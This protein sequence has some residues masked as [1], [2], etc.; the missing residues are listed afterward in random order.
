MGFGL[1]I[2]LSYLTA[3]LIMRLWPQ[4]TIVIRP[5]TLVGAGMAALVMTLFAALLPIRRV[6]A[7][8]PA[9]VFKA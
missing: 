3:D 7:I 5:G 6:A 4:F 1:G 9:V 8:D 2:S